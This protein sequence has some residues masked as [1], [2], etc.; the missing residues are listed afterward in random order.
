MLGGTYRI[1]HRD[2][3]DNT[4]AELLEKHKTELLGVLGT[5]EA[6][7][8]KMPKVKKGLSTVLRQDD[9]LVI[10][11]KHEGTTRTI[12][13]G[14]SG[15]RTLRIPVTFRNIRT[16][17]VYEKTLVAGDFTDKKD[18]TLV[19]NKWVAAAWYDE[20]EY[21]IPAQSE[22]KLGHNLQDVRVDSAINIQ[23]DVQTS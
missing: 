16:N 15:V 22:L 6:D 14:T 18:I 17:I 8:Q 2:A 20:E 5:P 11:Y 21:I 3:N 19:G 23:H 12:V 4:I 13:T 10:M 9:K 7:A 1:V